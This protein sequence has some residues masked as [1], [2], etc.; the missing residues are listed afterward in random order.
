MAYGEG[1]IWQEKTKNGKTVWRVEIVV[2]KKPNGSPIITRRTA[3]TQ[4]AARNLRSDLNSAKN[5]GKLTQQSLTTVADFGRHWAREVIVHSVKPSTATGYEWLL[6]KY[7]Y[8]FLGN[9]RMS[10]L[11]YLDVVDWLNSLLLGH[12]STSTV[13]S[14]RAVLG[15]LCKQAVRVGILGTNPVPL[16]PKAKKSAGDKTQVKP[17]WT[18]EEA[19]EAL[20]CSKGTDM[21]LFVHLSVL[22]GL[23]LGETLG[24]KWSSVD[25]ERRVLEIRFT[26]KDERRET[27]TGKGVV[28]L[29]LQE[30]K[31]KSSIR[32][33]EIS[34]NLFAA[35]E[36][37]KMVQSVRKISA[38]DKWQESGMVFTSSVGTA[39]YQANIRPFFYRFLDKHEIRRI[40]IHDMRH[41]YGTL[42]I[43]SGSPLEAVSQSM[44]HADIG[45]TKKIYAPDVRGLNEKALRG[46]DAYLDPG[47]AVQHTWAG[48]AEEITQHPLEV[49][50]P[51]ALSRRQHGLKIDYRPKN[52]ANN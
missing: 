26:L 25:F 29:K 14:A 21:D 23:R 49:T 38:G 27:S 13:N 31:T 33:L 4:A 19:Q 5:Q 7:V 52:K 50:S 34:K 44:G 41:T 24:L 1:S 10:E 3:P 16:T 28:Q 30:P 45:I 12:L 36:R 11:K 17:S 8:P 42:A 51:V 35:F 9:R 39:V 46:L 47:L 2:G 15:Q 18:K 48:G 32:K 22:M 43:E 20:R 40:R 37:H 6:K